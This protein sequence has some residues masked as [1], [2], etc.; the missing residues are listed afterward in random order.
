[1]P[2]LPLCGF[3]VCLFVWMLVLN[4]HEIGKIVG[5]LWFIAGILMYLWY[6]R[7]QKIHW[8]DHI[9]GTQVTH[10]EIA[11]ELHPEIA[12]ELKTRYAGEKALHKSAEKGKTTYNNIL[13]PLARLETIDNIVEITCD[14][15]G[16]GGHINLINCH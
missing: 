16:T 9:P 14:L 5:T 7:S 15:L 6:R 2:I 3:F 13:V 4:L 10:P 12:E 11:H 8:R 1:M